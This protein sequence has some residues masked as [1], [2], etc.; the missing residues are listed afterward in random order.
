MKRLV[1]SL[2]L[3]FLFSYTN[4]YSAN[5]FWISGGAANW[6]NTANWSTTSGGASGASVPVNIDI[7]IFN[8][9]GLGSCTIDAAA[10]VLG[11]SIA[12]GYTG[13]VSFNAGITLTVGASN[14][15][16]AAGTFTGNNGN[17]TINASFNLSAGTFTSTAG[18]LQITGGYTFSGGTFNH[19]NG[20]VT[21]SGTQTFSG[22]ISLYDLTFAASGADYNIGAGQ[23]I[24]SNNS[25]TII[26]ANWYRINTGTLAIKGNLNLTSSSNNSANGGSATYLFNGTG[27]QTVTSAAA[28]FNYVAALGKVQVNKTSGTLNFVG[29]I[30]FNGTTWINTA[31]A[32]LINAGTSTLNILNNATTFSGQDLTLY[33]IYIPATGQDINITAGQKLTS[34]NLITINGTNWYRINTGIL[35]IKGNLNLTTSSN[36]SANGG[37]A[38]YLFNGTGAQT[39][40]SGAIAYDYVAALGKV[41]VNKVSGT[42]NFIGIINFNGTTWITTAGTSLINA[43]TSTVNILN[44]T[45]FSGQDLALYDIYIPANS[46]DVNIS[47]GLKLTS[48]NLVTISGSSWYR[49]NTGILEIKGNLNL[50]TSSNNSANGGSATYLF[51]GTGA[52][53]VTSGAVAYNY[54]AALGKVQVNKVSG[55]LNF[56][57]IINFNGTT[58]ITT[59]GTSLIN[60]GTSTLN[61]LNTTT[62]S[63]QDLTL[64]DIY[65]PANSQDINLTAGLFLT[66][67]NNVIINGSSWY[68]IN[69]GTLEIKG[70]LTLT[71]SSNNSANGGSATYLFDGTGAQ[72][73]NASAVSTYNYI[74]AIGNVQINKASGSLNISGVFN[75]NGTSWNTIAGNT[76]IV[77]GTSAVNIL[78]TCTLSGQNISLYDIFIPGTSQTITISAGLTWTSSNLITLAGSSWYAINTGTFNPKGDVT[79]T[80]SATSTGGTGTFLFNGTGNQLLTGSGSSNRGRLPAVTIDKT[81][82]TLTFGSNLI[83]E[84]NNWTYVQGTVDATTNNSLVEFTGTLTIDGQG[85]SSTMKFYDIQTISGTN[86]LGGNLDVGHNI[87]FISGSID[88]STTLYPITIQGNWIQNFNSATAFNERTGSVTF[89]GTVAQ[90]IFDNAIAAGETFCNLVINNA[91]GVTLGGTA[92]YNVNISGTTVGLNLTSGLLTTSTSNLIVVN[93]GAV[94]TNYSSTSYVDGP[95]RKIGAQAFIFPTGKAG[96]YARIAIGVPTVSSTYT[97]EYFANPFSNT[98]SMAITPTPVLM[99][100]STMEYWQLDRTGTGNATVTLYWEDAAWSGIIDCTSSDLRVAHWNGAAWE[101]NNDVVTT[102]AGC[103]G[104]AAGTVKT[105]ANV[106]SFSPFTF[107]S[108][109]GINPLPIELLSFTAVPNKNK[110]DLNWV[111]ASEINNDY[112]NIERSVDGINFETVNTTDGAGNSTSIIN[113]YSVDANPYNGLSY[114]RLKQTDFNGNTSYSQTVPVEFNSADDFAFD[115][116]PNPAGNENININIISSQLVSDAYINFYDV[117][118]KKIYST[119]ITLSAKGHTLFSFYPENKLARGVYFVEISSGQTNIHKKLIV[120]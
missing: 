6:N 54:V 56:I 51:N 5:R 114:Y 15:T 9:A 110:V 16:Q 100:V 45:T 50:T 113:Y 47:S 94:A 115:I 36:N 80:N 95:I 70:D 24:T 68:R 77:P 11:F 88:V 32:S 42:L 71:A 75:F 74:C 84:M 1:Y 109:K 59:A 29:I 10:N 106:T 63:G 98:T 38:T 64:Y 21:F 73:I 85:A 65:I 37:S 31:G 17:I 13:A 18:T 66:S 72:N 12:T 49:I 43:G 28:A 102:T 107:G 61:I 99:N 97:A 55:T 14:F 86:T 83:S 92:T 27:A 91:A 8:G 3:I 4:S 39:I 2:I 23:T 19:N 105:T 53:N 90:T 118:G 112:F 57:G 7:A 117:T 62:F 89:N 44:T 103:V 40:T 34:T 111:T 79:I 96:R 120:K 35:E 93:S 22:N 52:Q 41:Q 108:T 119:T 78:N 76:L 60:A 26:G 67:T 87:Q 101:N 46:Q 33:D 20:A 58:W 25:L 104:S 81:G 69:T 82:G 116:Y 48:T 30:N